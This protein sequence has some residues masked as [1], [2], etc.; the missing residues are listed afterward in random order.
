MTTIPV[1]LRCWK[2]RK[3]ERPKDM[4]EKMRGKTPFSNLIYY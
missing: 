2:H 1:Q 3:K 4:E